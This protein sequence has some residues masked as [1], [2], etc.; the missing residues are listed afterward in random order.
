MKYGADE[1]MIALSDKKECLQ[2]FCEFPN[3]T[4]KDVTDSIDSM[5]VKDKTEGIRLSSIHKA[6]GLEADR[7][8][9]LH[10]EKLP[11]PMAKTEEAQRQEWNLKYVAITRAKHLLAEV[12]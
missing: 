12:V 6:K 4:V 11:H 1:R 3:K 2:A 9:I 5:F 8:Y 10:P 7:V